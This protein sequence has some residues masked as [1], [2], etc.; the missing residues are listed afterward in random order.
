MTDWLRS[1]DFSAFDHS[2]MSAL[3]VSASLGARSNMG[4]AKFLRVFQVCFFPEL[5]KISPHLPFYR[6]VWIVVKK[7]LKRT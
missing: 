5:L 2:I 1:L 7:S 3:W 4:Q 6:M